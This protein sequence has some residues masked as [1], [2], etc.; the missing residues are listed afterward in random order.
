MLTTQADGGEQLVANI[1]QHTKRYEDLFYQAVQKIVPATGLEVWDFTVTTANKHCAQV[2]SELEP[3]DVLLQQRLQHA[4][5]R[6]ETEEDV[7]AMFP[8]KLLRR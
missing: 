3:V 7:R 1:T 4:Q 2:S 6:Q 5:R 8:P